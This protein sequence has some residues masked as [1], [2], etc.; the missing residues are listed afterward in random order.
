MLE[1]AGDKEVVLGKKYDE[2]LAV[3]NSG[4]IDQYVRVTVNLTGQMKMDQKEN[5]S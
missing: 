1:N 3:K 2:Q 5:R 4:T